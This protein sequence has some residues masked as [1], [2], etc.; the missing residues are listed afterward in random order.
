MGGNLVETVSPGEFP[1]G[2][3]KSLV[4]RGKKGKKGRVEGPINKKTGKGPW[5]DRV[6]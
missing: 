5:G 4:D 1:G 6:V 2:G 3:N